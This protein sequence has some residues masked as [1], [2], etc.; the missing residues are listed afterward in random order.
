MVNQ[1]P[2][3]PSLANYL[4]K[5]RVLASLGVVSR[6]SQVR[7]LKR[8]CHA[9]DFS[10]PYTEACGLVPPRSNSLAYFFGDS[11]SHLVSDSEIL[12]D[13]EGE[14]ERCCLI[15]II[16]RY[17]YGAIGRARSERALMESVK[18]G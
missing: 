13:L 17:G 8:R 18:D 3:C 14:F 6:L 16:H 4:A 12:G 7:V 11:L 5:R 1:A 15:L 2:R 9:V 10:S